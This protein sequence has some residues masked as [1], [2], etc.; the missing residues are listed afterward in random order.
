M[1]NTKIEKAL[2]RLYNEE[3]QRIVFWNDPDLEFSITLSLLRSP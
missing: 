2:A 1:E 3:N